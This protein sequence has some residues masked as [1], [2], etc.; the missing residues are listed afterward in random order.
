M[1]KKLIAAASSD[2]LLAESDINEVGQCT[3]RTWD[4][5]CTI[6]EVRGWPLEENWESDVNEDKWG[7]VRRLESNWFRF[8]RA[9]HNPATREKSA[10]GK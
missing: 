1:H 2:R 9:R 7:A 6:A 8:R 5:V 10:R 4:I 3:K